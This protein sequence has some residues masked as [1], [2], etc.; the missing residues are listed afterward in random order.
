MQSCLP[1]LQVGKEWCAHL[2]V[3]PPDFLPNDTAGWPWRRPVPNLGAIESASVLPTGPETTGGW[4]PYLQRSIE[5]FTKHR[6]IVARFGRFPHRNRVLGR[7]NTPAK[8]AFLEEGA[9]TFG[10]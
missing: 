8:Q 3:R 9:A 10:Q 2:L 1:D 7:N 5:G 4:Q 6:E